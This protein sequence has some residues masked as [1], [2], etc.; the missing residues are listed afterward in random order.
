VKLSLFLKFI[1]QNY[2][3]LLYENI[4]HNNFSYLSLYLYNIISLKNTNFLLT[5]TF[6][7]KSSIK[8][9]KMK[10]EVENKCLY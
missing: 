3:L 10:Y 8:N 2:F 4:F 5:L 1:T 7:T 6:F 9:K